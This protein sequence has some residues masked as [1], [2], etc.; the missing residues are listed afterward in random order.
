M[1]KLLLVVA[2]VPLLSYGQVQIGAD[3]DGDAEYDKSGWSVS[4]SSDGS[5]VAIGAKYND[6]VNGGASGQVRIFENV[7]GSWTQIGADI[8]GEAAGD[9]S[10]WSVSLSGD[11]S[12]VAIGADSN[13]GING[14]NSGHVRIFEN[15]GGSWTQI[16]A[17]IDGDAEFDG[18]GWSVSLSGDGSIVAI[19]ADS[20]DGINGEN[21]GHVRIFENVGGSWTQIGADIDGDA[22]FDGSGSNVSL[23]SDGSIVA[24][25]AEFNDGNGEDS[26]QVRIFENVGGSWTQIGAD[27]DGEAEGD[28]LGSSVSLSGDGSTVAIGAIGNDGNGEDSGQVRIF[29]NVGGSWTQIGADIDGEAEFDESGW[30]V[31]LSSDGSIVAI[32]ADGNDGNGYRS[33]QVRIFENVG[34]SWTQV[35]ADIDGEAADDNSGRS[36]SLSNDGSIVAIGAPDNSQNGDFSGHVRVYSVDAG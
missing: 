22:E 4:L 34:G 3:I 15:V 30:S 26:G 36:V 18:S 35:R 21:S 8:D 25:G 23:S 28:L 32:G 27:I 24:I 31:S 6:G 2:I 10:G 19:G 7:G 11:G 17:D 1:K 5:I 33:G 13:D 14:E 29:E 20:N 9:R 16:G 12:I